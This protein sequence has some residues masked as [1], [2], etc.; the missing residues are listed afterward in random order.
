VADLVLVTLG[1]VQRFLGES[2]TTAD[3]AGASG[4][5]Q[6]LARCAAVKAHE[7]LSEWPRP[8]GLIVPAAPPAPNSTRGTTN[9]IAFLAP[10][11]D[12]PELA[13][14][15][16]RAI[17]EEWAARVERV[18][19]DGERT[20]G[21]PDISWVSVSGSA[22][23]EHYGQLWERAR[24]ALVARRRARVFAPLLVKGRSLCSQ[25][26]HL[27]ASDPPPTR[28]RHER[29]ERL[30]AAGW[31]K[32]MDA[33]QGNQENTAYPSTV[34][35]ASTSFRVRLIGK[36]RE[37]GDERLIAAVRRLAAVAQQVSRYQERPLPV[38]DVPDDVAPLAG[39]LGQWVYPERWDATALRRDGVSGAGEKAQKGRAA[40]IALLAEAKRLKVTPPSPYY[41][42]VVQDLD[43]LGKAL[44]Q[45]TLE[46]HRSVSDALGAL[47]EAQWRAAL[48]L[49]LPARPVYAGGDDFL[50]FSPAAS[51]LEL[52]VAVRRS[53]DERAEAAGLSVNGRPI[54]ASTAVVFVHMGSPLQEAIETAQAAL[55]EAKSTERYGQSRD[56]LCVVVR[57]RGGERA[58]L[59]QPWGEKLDAVELLGQVRPAQPGSSLSP[60]L[61]SRLEQDAGS[62]DELAANGLWLALS[63]E[64]QRLVERQGGDED[65]G[66]A[67]FELGR[68]ERSSAA[69]ATA[70]R[71][72]P[73]AFRPVPA[74]LTA[75]FL[76]QECK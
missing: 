69:T 16:A 76:T 8:F 43:R 23:P 62:F 7:L 28:R 30:S 10:D 59:I 35:I 48:E 18:F 4:V 70:A 54:T 41:A 73:A 50:A 65:A 74:A 2:R 75:R 36:A 17:D 71:P 31:V 22:E 29:N 44:N 66:A 34:A 27:P 33:R 58:R 6:A 1:G 45:L 67:L 13:R 61:A 26:P 25:A 60:G 57:R 14:K 9:K 53:V 63:K 12:G 24:V 20:P 3:V 19:P 46:Q 49:R 52:V 47:A 40:A 42:V 64:L 55:H 72:V 15:V 56:A 32:R 39:Q 38:D 11:G 68:R 51:A 21:M 37:T 5:I